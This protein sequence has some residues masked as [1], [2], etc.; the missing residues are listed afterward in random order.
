MKELDFETKLLHP[1]ISNT[2]GATITPIYQNTAF[3]HQSAES[4]ED[5]FNNR[6]MGYCYTRLTNPTVDAFERRMAK[7][8]NGLTAIATAS[9]MA[10]I[11][12][13]I[14]NLVGAGDE[15]VAS[16]SLYGGTIDMFTDLEGLGMVVKYAK[17]TSTGDFAEAVTDNTKIVFAETVGNPR[18]DVVDIETLAEIAHEHKAVLIID[19]TVATPYL[20]NPLDLGAD[21]V[22]HSTS[23]YIN[24]TSNAIGGVIICGKNAVYSAEKFPLLKDFTKFGAMA[25]PAKMRNTVH[26]HVGATMAPQT[27]F[28][29]SIGLD[30]LAVRVEKA[31]NNAL[32]LAK[33]LQS[34]ESVKVNYLALNEYSALAKKLLKGYYGAII[35]IR[36]GSKEKAFKLLNS[37]KLPMILSNIGDTKTLVI[38]PA[39][40]ISLHS[41][42]EQKVNAGVYDDLIRISVGIE[43]VE[44]L[45]EDFKNAINVAGLG[46]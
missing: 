15:I 19:N 41:T 40:T 20:C 24:G 9:G 31:C 27:A 3:E 21:I 7:L 22:I 46:E 33:F 43:S 16:P 45:K 44:D 18:L 10:A 26:Q 1:D 34:Y 2:H 42:E 35:T 28:L 6:T 8:E 13:S 23:K 25:F 14:V 38:H 11:Y 32:G 30:T 39:S 5:L 36:V 37:L 17:G 29:N 4:I 12:N